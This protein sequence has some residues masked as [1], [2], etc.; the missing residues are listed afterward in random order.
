MITF[1]RS[2]ASIVAIVAG[3]A[4]GLGILYAWQ[5]PP[6]ASAVQT[7]DNAYVRGFVTVLSPQVT[8]NIAEVAVKDYEKVAQG[9]LLI[10]IDDR[11]YKQKLEQ[12]EASLASKK[13]ALANSFQ[14]EKSANAKILSAEAQIASAK[15]GLHKA[16]LN[17]QR[18]EPLT[19]RGVST[20]SD[21]DSA[22]AALDQATAAKEQADAGLDVAKQDLQTIIVAR[23]GLEADVNGAEAAVALA[24]ID[25]DHTNIYSPRDGRVG[26]VG[27]KLGQYVAIGTQ[28]LAV[29]PDDVWVVA[30]YKETQLANMKIG[31]PA[32][33]T[34]D[35]LNNME[36]KGIVTRFSPAAGSEFSVLKPDNAT[37]NFTKVAQRIPVRIEIDPDQK[38]IDRLAPGMS[39]MV[40][41]DTAKPGKEQVTDFNGDLSHIPAEVPE[42]ATQSDGK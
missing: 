17:W 16:E 35:A 41:V 15:A 1:L 25:L 19:Q 2:K 39:V 33:F 5:L 28:L 32:T 8:G 40:H 42:N 14:Q 24:Q 22:R 18:I 30:N 9:Q 20:Q 34:V 13:A 6:F 21:A 36:M 12:A 31:Q 27:A 29:V 7:T 26:E 37:G 10:R 23:K 38:G 4:G 3:V 11:I